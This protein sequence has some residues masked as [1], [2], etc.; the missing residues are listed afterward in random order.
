MKIG[1]PSPIEIHK[2]VSKLTDVDICYANLLDGNKEYQKLFSKKNRQLILVPGLIPISKEKY[3]EW[4][5]ILKPDW[6][7]IPYI[8]NDRKNTIGN[9]RTWNHKSNSKKIGVIQGHNKHELAAC[10]TSLDPFVDMI[11]ISFD[12]SAFELYNNGSTFS[13]TLWKESNKL[14]CMT[15]ARIEFIQDLNKSNFVNKKK[16]H[17]LLGCACPYEGWH[18]TNYDWIEYISTDHPV[19]AGMNGV[20]YDDE[21]GLVTKVNE[22]GT[23]GIT[24]GYQ[25]LIKR[26]IQIFKNLWRG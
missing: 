12:Y 1:H 20:N 21:F 9:I 15:D 18:Y 25:D 17:I 19:I 7:I 3:I 2:E 6:Y 24:I 16:P 10:Y 13:K 14:M 11:A 5:D 23:S 26:N 4:I 22:I 8:K